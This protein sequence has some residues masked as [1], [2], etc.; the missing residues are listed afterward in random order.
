MCFRLGAPRRSGST[1][2]SGCLSSK[3]GRTTEHGRPQMKLISTMLTSGTCINLDT[4]SLWAGICVLWAV[5][6][7][8]RWCSCRASLLAR[9][10]HK[11]P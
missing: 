4:V 5:V 6:G 1:C 8:G 7:Q 9:Q 2:S 10:D 3:A 11:L